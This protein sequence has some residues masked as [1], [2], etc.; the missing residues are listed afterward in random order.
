MNVAILGGGL[1]GLT[2]AHELVSAGHTI[3]LFEKNPRLGG[4]AGGMKQPGWDWYLDYTYHHVFTTDTAILELAKNLRH[5]F[6][7]SAPHTDTLFGDHHNYRIFPVDTPQDLLLLPELSLLSRLRAG[8]VLA[9]LKISP[10][11]SAYE[12]QTARAF[13]SSTMGEEVWEK[14]WKPLFRKKFGKYAE[15]V[16]ASFIWAR[17]NKR[18]RSLGYPTGGFQLLIDELAEV[19]QKKGGAIYTRS[20]IVDIR[21]QGAQ[22]TLIDKAGK[23]SAFDRIIGTVPFPVFLTLT[24]HIL[25]TDYSA[26]QRR[27]KYLWA[28]NMIVETERPILSTTYWLNVNAEDVPVMCVVQHTNFVSSTHFGNKHIAYFAWYVPDNDPLLTASQD[29]VFA[30]VCTSI[31]QINPSFAGSPQPISLFRVPYAQPIFDIATV[32]ISRALTTPT[33]GVYVANLDMTYPFDRGTNYAVQLGKDVSKLV[34]SH[35]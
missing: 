8:V 31:A 9:F 20:E 13:L 1:T 14:M 10:F 3:T 34:L 35:L 21:K 25:P 4:L 11:L 24:Q 7:F 32:Q 26:M 30:Q 12:T 18:S 19:V 27:R 5:P 15:I 2:A 23:R 33:P 6:V 16:V 29:E 17:I 22:F 28:V